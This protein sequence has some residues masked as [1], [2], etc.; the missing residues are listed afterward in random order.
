MPPTD[1]TAV[2]PATL[3]AWA[4]PEPGT[5]KEARGQVLVLGGTT[6][7]PGAVRLAG[8]A[9]LRAGAGKLALA[10]VSDTAG[11]L[12]VAVPEAQVLALQT[13]EVSVAARVSDDIVRR[14]EEVAVLLVGPGFS[15]VS[16]TTS[17]LERVIPHL[18][19][20]IVIDAIA[21]AYLTEHP[22]ALHHLEG[23]VVLTVNPHELAC[24]AELD[25]DDVRRDALGAARAVAERSQVV[26]LCGGT[27]KYIVAPSG[28]AWVIEGGGPGLGV[29]GSGDVQAGIVAGLLARCADPAQAAVWG[30]YLH[31]RAGEQ[32]AASVGT[33]GFLARQLT[34]QVPVALAE[35]I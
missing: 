20:A 15:D 14:A 35:L 29:S 23:R 33:V 9:A 25:E 6:Q 31:A 18:R 8:E 16:A 5:D 13:D 26:V 4:L 7:T 32:L 10:T 30:G 3:R 27:S 22:H 34:A 24:T 21:S 28:E 12:A 1:S 19:C 2:T 11:A 17:L